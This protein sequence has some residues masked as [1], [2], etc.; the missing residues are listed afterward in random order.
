MNV[1]PSFVVQKARRNDKGKGLERQTE[2]RLDA[3]ENNYRAIDVLDWYS[4]VRLSLMASASVGSL[5]FSWLVS[6]L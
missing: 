3:F 2:G 1:I 5:E 6:I 4:V